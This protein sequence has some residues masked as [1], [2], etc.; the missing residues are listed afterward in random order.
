M[1]TKIKLLSLIIVASL[2]LVLG[3][4]FN[5]ADA[6]IIPPCNN[7]GCIDWTCDSN[8]NCWDIC[9]PAEGVHCS[10]S[11]GECSTAIC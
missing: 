2:S 4:S 8:D 11:H 6:Y 10:G 9:V 7:E 5:T 3:S 1:K